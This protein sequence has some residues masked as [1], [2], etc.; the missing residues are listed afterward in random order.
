MLVLPAV[1]IRTLQQQM[2]DAMHSLTDTAGERQVQPTVGQAQ[3]DMAALV[4]MQILTGQTVWPGDK[5]LRIAR[6]RPVESG[7]TVIQG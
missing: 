2:I 6:P 7:V 3:L 4:A 1:A 5:P